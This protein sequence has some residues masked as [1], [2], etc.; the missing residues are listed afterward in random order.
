MDARRIG[1]SGLKVSVLGLGTNNFGGRLDEEASRKVLY[2]ALDAGVT[3][4]DT[5]DVYPM[6]TFGTSEEIIGRALKGRRDQVVLATKVGYGAG[7][8]R[9]AIIAA[10]EAS[11]ARLQTDHVD[12]LYFHRP[13]PDTPIDETIG[14]LDEITRAGKAR[15]VAGSNMA[16][17]QV[18]QAQ[19]LAR[20]LG[21]HRFI[22]SQE[23]YSMLT[24]APEAEV[25]P[26]CKAYGVGLVPFFPLES[27][28]LTG[29]YRPGQAIPEGSR[30][31]KSPAMAPRFLREDWLARAEEL[32]LIAEG[33]GKELTDLAFG[34]LLRDPVVPSVIAGASSPEQVQRNAQAAAW[35]VPEDVIAA[36]G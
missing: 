5:A 27:G 10:V 23:Y 28:V 9:R 36:V 8:S 11:L 25:I 30:M 2:A 21:A 14:A 19:H 7:G 26:A 31:A 20:E 6:S 35:V 33:A 18:V 24:R 1:T 3:H 34:W 22:A 29:K 15:Y 32:R 12:L 16:A 17:W 13:D 4:I